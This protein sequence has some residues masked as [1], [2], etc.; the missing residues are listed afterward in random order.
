[1]PNKPSAANHFPVVA[2][3][4]SAGGID[5]LKRFFGNLDPNSGLGFVLVQHLSPEHK[6]NLVE[7][8][9]RF[10]DMPVVEARDGEAVRLDT[11]HVIPA[12]AMLTFE[13]GALKVSSP[14]DQRPHN[15]IDQ[16]FS[17]LAEDLGPRAVAV[18]LS[19]YGD[20]GSLGVRSIHEHGGLVLAQG[21]DGQEP[22]ADD[23]PRNAVETGFVDDVLPVTEM[24]RRLVD[25][26]TTL[27]RLGPGVDDGRGVDDRQA[28]TLC[29]L[30]RAEVGHDF[31]GYKRKTFGRRV[32]R[33]MAA[34]NIDDPEA[35]IAHCRD[36]PAE[37]ER[38]F[39]ELLI[40]VTQFFR[41]PDAFKA[42]AREIVPK[43]FEDKGANGVV[44]VWVPG[45]ATGEE[46][47][48]LAIL[49]R[50]HMASQRV[51]PKVQIFATDIDERSLRIAR[52]AIYGKDRLGGMTP[53][54]LE[55]F[56]RREGENWRLIKEV[57]DMCI[58]STHNLLKDPP[59]SHLDLI[60][61]RNLLIYFDADLQERLIPLFHYALN[62]GGHLFIGP[63]ENI[64]RHGE[65]FQT[66]DKRHRLYRRRDAVRVHVPSLASP[67]LRIGLG[68]GRRS[69]SARVDFDVSEAAERALLDSFSPAYVVV[70]DTFNVVRF[71]PRTGRY[72]EA[73]AGAPERNLISLA[74]K[75]LRLD[76]RAALQRSTKTG[77][78]VVHPRV[79]F[80]AEDGLHEVR[81]VAQRLSP[82]E[83]EAKLTL[84]V[85][86]D[87][88]PI[89]ADVEP[90][91]GSEDATA[92]QLE[93]EL[94]ATR[95]LLQSTVEEYETSSEDLRS[96][97]VE[98]MSLNEEL[99]SSNEELETSK[100]ELQ[101]LNEELQTVNLEV[102][103]K[104]EELDRANNDLKNLI[105]ST[106]IA[107]LFLDRD[108]KVGIFTPAVYNVVRL[109]PSDIG[110]PI[111]DIAHDL[112]NVAL[113]QIARTVID[114]EKSV[115]FEARPKGGDADWVVRALP[116]KDSDGQT[117]G[118]VLTF[119]DVTRLKSAD[120]QTA[121][122]EELNHRVKNILSVV[123]SIASQ[124]TRDAGT[125][126]DFKTAFLARLR[127]LANSNELLAARDWAGA[128]LDDLVNFEL[129]P[130]AGRSDGVTVDGPNLL[131]TPKA[132]VTL[133]LVLHEMCTNAAKY[134]ALADPSRRLAVTWA[135]EGADEGAMLRLVWAETGGMGIKSP[136]KIGFGSHVISQSVEYELGGGVEVDFRDEGVAYVVL[137]PAS[138]ALLEHPD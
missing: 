67:L 134:G 124:M 41:D 95:E 20:D 138:A 11:I 128:R 19:G 14:P 63:S 122:V 81:L 90:D 120:R 53:E 119:V 15:P 43:L 114:T 59:Y 26:A 83:Q 100:E 54:R 10:T 103:T 118:V 32:R 75:G 5:A 96:S 91:R 104:V 29:D 3:G 35:Y 2:I 31:Q 93:L 33:R 30:L 51:A 116:Y 82:P 58:F 123:F 79:V 89:A 73:P 113:D 44:R 109:I 112:S 76:L 131:L 99:Q 71:S 8:L 62:Q 136:E 6:S 9:S 47:F 64:T 52:T 38:L 97:N 65:L 92:R 98:L 40:G 36:T 117:N 46:A 66:I 115:E 57:R 72:L 125:T 42:V 86:Q 108:L 106:Q 21:G 4:A 49:L 80:E 121:L 70:D 137:V 69:A 28:E 132:A 45:C 23:M 74:R 48:S 27:G 16:F 7:I 39:D 77:E 34:L 13:S 61:C 50:E 68:V 78:T 94:R 88:G 18:V 87:L 37:L 101:S 135:I 25:H 110:R 127:A 126:E 130:Y 133:G 55:R 129:K 24:P 12:G 17:S 111:T 85:F 105:E 84:V 102:H 1:M 22:F 107:T 60:S 56:F